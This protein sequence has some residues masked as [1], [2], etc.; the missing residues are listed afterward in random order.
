MT[1]AAGPPIGSRQ[2][3]V[4]GPPAHPVHMEKVESVP[5]PTVPIVPLVT[6]AASY[7]VD[8]RDRNC[9]EIHGS[10]VEIAD[11]G[12]H[13][14]AVMTNEKPIDDTELARLKQE[15]L[16]GNGF[17]IAKGVVPPGGSYLHSNKGCCARNEK[18]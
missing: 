16:H 9:D 3:S 13:L 14:H 1:A 17:I 12:G 6:E 18:I 5:P 2:V 10:T 7:P 11:A 8:M 4:T 15:M